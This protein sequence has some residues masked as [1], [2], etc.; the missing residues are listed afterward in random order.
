MLAIAQNAQ[1]SREKGVSES[2][3]WFSKAAGAKLS[4]IASLL[5][6]PFAHEDLAIVLGGYAVVN[7]VMPVLSVAITIYVGMVVSDFA[8]YGIGAGA[9]RFPWLGDYAIDE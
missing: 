4:W 7:D 1:F 2:L 3:A 8:L 5:I 6:L 9:R